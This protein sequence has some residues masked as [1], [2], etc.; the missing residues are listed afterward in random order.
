MDTARRLLIPALVLA[1]AGCAARPS[2]TPNDAPLT[3]E[4]WK[5]LPPGD[6]YDVETFERLKLGHPKLQDQRAWDRFARDV[7]LPGRKRELPAA[8]PKS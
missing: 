8:R 7:V 1:A 5:T 2:G 6:K 3:L 4:Q